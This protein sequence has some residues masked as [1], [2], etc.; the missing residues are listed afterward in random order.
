MVPK[1]EGRSKMLNTWQ[2]AGNSS[3]HCH[4]ALSDCEQEGLSMQRDRRVGRVMAGG[5]GIST[6]ALG[7]A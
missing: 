7:F 4:L 2:T 6:R 3:P 5:S 1:K